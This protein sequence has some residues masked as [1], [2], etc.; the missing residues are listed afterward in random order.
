MTVADHTLESELEALEDDHQC[1]G[2]FGTRKMEVKHQPL[3][4]EPSDLAKKA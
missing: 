4:N 3:S 1:F 2:D